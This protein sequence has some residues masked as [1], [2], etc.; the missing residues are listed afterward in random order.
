MS[1]RRSDNLPNGIDTPVRPWRATLLAN[2]PT[3]IVIVLT[4]RRWSSH[5]AAA[6]AGGGE[7]QI[8]P[9]L[10]A[11]LDDELRNLD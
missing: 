6:V 8:D 3:L 11:R 7:T 10:D 2:A 5:P 4:A 1:S 9:G